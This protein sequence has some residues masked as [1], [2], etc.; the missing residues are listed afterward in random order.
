MGLPRD[1]FACFRRALSRREREVFDRLIETAVKQQDEKVK[2]FRVGK[3]VQDIDP[4]EAA[5]LFLLLE[6]EK[7]IIEL[8]SRFME[9]SR[10]Q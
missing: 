10:R 2:V 4:V 1:S 8:R 9:K 3:L 6:H 5:F 7:E